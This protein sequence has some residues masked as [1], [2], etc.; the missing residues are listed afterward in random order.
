MCQVAYIYRFFAVFAVFPQ[1][2][3]RYL[4]YTNKRPWDGLPFLFEGTR[5]PVS[6]CVRSTGLLRREH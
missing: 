5:R 4:Y 6:P 2:H 1:H 3:M